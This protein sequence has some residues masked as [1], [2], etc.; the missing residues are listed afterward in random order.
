MAAYAISG[1]IFAVNGFGRKEN[2]KQKTA[3]YAYSTAGIFAILLLAL[4]LLNIKTGS[5]TYRIFSIMFYDLYNDWYLVFFSFAYT[6]YMSIKTVVDS[7]R[8]SA[9]MASINTTK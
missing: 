3:L 6:L 7:A 9:P 4:F 1:L 8:H 2:F 5:F